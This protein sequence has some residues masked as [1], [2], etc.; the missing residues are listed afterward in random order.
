MPDNF[1]I[2]SDDFKTLKLMQKLNTIKPKHI[3]TNS[4]YYMTQPYKTSFIYFEQKDI[5]LG[6]IDD[7]IISVK[8]NS[9]YIVI[10]QITYQWYQLNS[11]GKFNLALTVNNDVYINFTVGWDSFSN[12]MNVFYK[13]IPLNVSKNDIIKFEITNRN[14]P[15]LILNT[16]ITFEEY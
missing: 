5:D 1:K 11:I 4:S 14:T 16:I 10:V 15:L 9:N 7:G 3:L 13:Q 2:V 8:K 6:K 12:K